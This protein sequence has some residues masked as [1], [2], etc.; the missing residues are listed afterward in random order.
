MFVALG[1]ARQLR[2]IGG[3]L[4]RHMTAMLTELLGSSASQLPETERATYKLI[5]NVTNLQRAH[6]AARRRPS[7]LSRDD[8]R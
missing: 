8:V 1:A 5:R 6:V 4:S 3:L 7:P 2:V